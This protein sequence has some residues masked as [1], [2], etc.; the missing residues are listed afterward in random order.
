MV[1]VKHNKLEYYFETQHLLG[2]TIIFLFL[3]LRKI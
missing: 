2:N 3:I 1:T